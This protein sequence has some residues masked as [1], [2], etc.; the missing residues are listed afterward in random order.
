MPVAGAGTGKGSG[1]SRDTPARTPQPPTRASPSPASRVPTFVAPALTHTPLSLLLPRQPRLPSFPRPLP[2]ARCSD[3]PVAGSHGPGLGGSAEKPGGRAERTPAL[4]IPGL[5]CLPPV[6][7]LYRRPALLY[8]RPGPGVGEGGARAPVT[9]RRQPAARAPPDSALVP[10][11]APRRPG[12]ESR[13]CCLLGRRP[14][15]APRP[16]R[17]PARAPA[18]SRRWAAALTCGCGAAQRLG[19]VPLQGPRPL[20]MLP[21]VCFVYVLPDGFPEIA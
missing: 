16:A 10:A 18:S 9:G 5:A 4:P 15:S 8:N 21:R 1:Y 17:P 13:R 14:S 7:P 3:R 19:P 6:G 11:P 20:S 2:P 12:S